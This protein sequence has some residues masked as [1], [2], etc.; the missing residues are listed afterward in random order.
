MVNNNWNFMTQ[1]ELESV[2]LFFEK[3]A[4]SLVKEQH[5]VCRDLENEKLCKV[6]IG[7]SRVFSADKILN[8]RAVGT[9]VDQNR[10]FNAFYVNNKD[11]TPNFRLNIS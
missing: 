4:R 1:T 2:T 10:M 3:Q 8:E 9:E 7:D 6:Y 5:Y 11:F